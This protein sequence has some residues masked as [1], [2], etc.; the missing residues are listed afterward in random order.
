M[1]Y[2]AAAVTAADAAGGAATV[3]VGGGGGGGGD[4]VGRSRTTA[5]THQACT[6]LQMASAVELIHE[7]ASFVFYKIYRERWKT[8]AQ[9]NDDRSSSTE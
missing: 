6:S 9:H 1:R 3:G 8:R 2:T 7:R 4:V 5:Q